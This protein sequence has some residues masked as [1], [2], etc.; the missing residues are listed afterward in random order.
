MKKI[1]ITLITFL[2]ISINMQSTANTPSEQVK[3]NI[4]YYKNSRIYT[5]KTSQYNINLDSTLKGHKAGTNCSYFNL[6]TRK[7]VPIGLYNRPFIVF[8]KD[9]TIKISD[10][11]LDIVENEKAVSG[12]SWLVKDYKLYST[13]DHFSKDFKNSVVNR[14]CVGTDKNG[15]VFLVVITNTNLWK[16]ANIMRNIGCERAINLD[17]GSSSIMKYN[18]KIIISGRKVV[19]YLVIN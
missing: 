17:G 2:L 8:K 6:K 13:K 3:L 4:K 5:I 12:G 14:T 1:L 19:N 7:T 16:A 11:K 9:G 10:D 18:G 15:N